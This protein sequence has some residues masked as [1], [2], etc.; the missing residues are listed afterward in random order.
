M[1][2]ILYCTVK[3]KYWKKLEKHTYF[4]KK[5]YLC[6]Q[7]NS[8]LC[9]AFEHWQ[10]ATGKERKVYPLLDPYATASVPC[11][12]E[13]SNYLLQAKKNRTFFKWCAAKMLAECK[14]AFPK[15]YKALYL[16]KAC[17]LV[18]QG[19]KNKK[20]KKPNKQLL[21]QSFLDFSFFPS[22]FFSAF[23]SLSSLPSPS[24]LPSLLT[25]KVKALS[26]TSALLFLTLTLP[27]GIK[28]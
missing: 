10:K 20:T 7:W 12:S 24:S 18:C 17:Y 15:Q 19:K 5:P 23:V 3:S 11:R 9:F 6:C 2:V 22:L 13:K 26:T 28:L 14:S 1:C 8:G 21:L 16:F 4:P 27:R 25:L